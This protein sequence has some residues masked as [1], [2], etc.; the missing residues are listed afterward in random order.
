[1]ILKPGEQFTEERI[2]YRDENGRL[3]GPEEVENLKNGGGV[4]FETKYETRTRVVDEMGR[5]VSNEL[6][7]QGE[8]AAL[9]N[10]A[11][12]VK[13]TTV[14]HG[15][16]KEEAGTVVDAPEPMTVVRDEL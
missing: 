6:V 10:E 16:G 7:G 15:G 12:V 14:G 8:G 5:E 3:L 11:N 1:V 9:A 13:D 4:K 2:E